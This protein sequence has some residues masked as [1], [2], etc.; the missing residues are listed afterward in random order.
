M[1]RESC[2]GRDGRS[3]WPARTL[4]TASFLLYNQPEADHTADNKRQLSSRKHDH[5]VFRTNID[6]NPCT[7]S[8]PGFKPVLHPG[9]REC[10]TIQ[11]LSSLPVLRDA[12]MTLSYPSLLRPRS[13]ASVFCPFLPKEMPSFLILVLRVDGFIFSS[14]AAPFSPPTRPPVVSRARLM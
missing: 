6:L 3:R 8:M 7:G 4:P 2:K 9:P 1:E 12:M 10:P 11:F 5:P 13:L 14:F